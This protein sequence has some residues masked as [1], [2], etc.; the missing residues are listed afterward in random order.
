MTQETNAQSA[1]LTGLRCRCYKC[2]EGK[3]FDGYLRLKTACEVCGEDFAKGDTGDGPAFFVMFGALILFGPFYFLL[4]LVDWPVWAL[5]LALLTLTG[6]M[7]GFIF[8][9]LRPFKAILLNLQL[10]NNAAPAEFED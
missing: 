4:P 1:V 3:V 6:A 9:A 10:A 7:L 2:G 5:A 8:W